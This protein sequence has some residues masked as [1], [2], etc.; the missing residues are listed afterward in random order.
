MPTPNPDVTAATGVDWSSFVPDM[1]VAVFTGVFVGIAVLVVERWLSKRAAERDSA[2]AQSRAV[3]D[4]SRWMTA[5]L[6][7]NPDSLM[8]DDT[9][10]ERV[11]ARLSGVP[12]AVDTK[13]TTQFRIL[14]EY[15]DAWDA[16][17]ATAEK[18]DSQI[19]LITA[20]QRFIRDRLHRIIDAP[21]QRGSST[22]PQW[23]AI[24]QNFENSKAPRDPEFIEA[25][26]AYVSD[27]VQVETYR[28]AFVAWTGSRNT[29]RLRLG[30]MFFEAPRR[31]RWQKWRTNRLLKRSGREATSQAE[32]AATRVL[33]TSQAKSRHK[34]EAF[35]GPDETVS[36][37]LE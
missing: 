17:A 33:R 29:S 6:S 23:P 4:C 5:R 10:F 24:W 21:T 3:E 13:M 12:I 36:A 34:I 25:M 14:R 30:N 26:K 16:L 31:T 7:Y 2:K 28:Q 35:F 37:L 27:R 18:V 15:V 1:I 11:R 20:N 22:E 9:D 19:R 8:P 32:L